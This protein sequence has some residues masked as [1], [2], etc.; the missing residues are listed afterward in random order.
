MKQNNQQE[1]KKTNFTMTV[2][3]APNDIVSSDKREHQQ[4]IGILEEKLKASFIAIHLLNVRWAIKFVMRF[5][6]PFPSV[7]RCQA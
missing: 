5:F 1:N 6:L 2:K 3:R 7:G 4:H